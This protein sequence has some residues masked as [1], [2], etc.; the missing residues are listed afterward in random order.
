MLPKLMLAG[1]IYAVSQVAAP[2]AGMGLQA[3]GG[4]WS[5]VGSVA[6]AVTGG[7]AAAGGS[8]VLTAAATAAAPLAVAR[9][10][11]LLARD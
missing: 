11:S 2:V 6:G 8:G 9:N 7:G 1:K 4:L 5:G 3:A 10:L